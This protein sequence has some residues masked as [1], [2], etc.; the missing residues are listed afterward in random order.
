MW[1]TLIVAVTL[2]SNAPKSSLPSLR[3][4]IQVTHRTLPGIPHKQLG[5][6][7]LRY[8]ALRDMVA[9][10]YC[11][12]PERRSLVP[13]LAY[14]LSLAKDTNTPEWAVDFFATHSTQRVDRRV[15]KAQFR[16]MFATYCSERTN[17]S[18][19]ADKYLLERYHLK[20]IP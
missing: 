7:G 14:Q 10:W 1:P 13:C 9:K 15:A 3:R 16:T 20:K 19:C 8:L 4:P 6:E 12:T 5:T 17:D 18:I 11:T 2:L